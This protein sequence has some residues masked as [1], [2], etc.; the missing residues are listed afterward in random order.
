MYQFILFD[1][2]GTITNSEPGIL[3]SVRY[4]LGK[5][6][7]A[8]PDYPT[9]RKFIG[10]PLRDS[11]R[12]YCGLSPSGRRRRSGSTG[13]GTRPTGSWTAPSIPASPSCC[14]TFMQP[15]KRSPSPP[16]NR[17]GLPGI[18]LS[19]SA[20]PGILPPSAGR[21]WTAAGTGRSTCCGTC[22]YSSRT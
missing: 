21:R 1:L 14:G 22:W 4:A 10:P 13:S 18:S 12:D 15:G 11:F 17:R 2:D 3:A 20:L 9:L 5:L 7:A 6:G 16:P 8:E 19:I